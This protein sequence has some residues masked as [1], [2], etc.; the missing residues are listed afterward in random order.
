MRTGEDRD[1]LTAIYV[2]SPQT[3]RLSEQIMPDTKPTEQMR[4]T[5]PGL[6]PILLFK[7]PL[8]VQHYWGRAQGSYQYLKEA[9][10]RA[11]SKSPVNGAWKW[12]I[13]TYLKKYKI[14]LSLALFSQMTIIIA[15]PSSSLPRQIQIN[16]HFSSKIILLPC[17][18]HFLCD[19]TVNTQRST[20]E[21]I[22]LQILSDLN[23]NPYFKGWEF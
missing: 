12:Q 8:R 19:L 9:E 7:R 22:R 1:P 20:S 11:Q 2:I 17:P 15:H 6:G 5:K 16:L 14:N 21:T 23:L 4:F 3:S 13:N 10:E 18:N